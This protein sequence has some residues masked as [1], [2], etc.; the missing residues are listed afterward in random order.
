MIS[1]FEETNAPFV[2]TEEDFNERP[3]RSSKNNKKG[4]EA[5]FKDNNDGMDQQQLIFD[6]DH[7]KKFLKEDSNI[8][9]ARNTPPNKR[10]GGV[11]YR[12]KR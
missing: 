12:R 4:L 6:E 2:P 1:L 3:E 9:D 5:F 11:V 7:F 10:N 8:N